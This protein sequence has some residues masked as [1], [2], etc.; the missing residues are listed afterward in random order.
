ML[1]VFERPM[2]VT[3]VDDNCRLFFR[4]AFD[5]FKSFGRCCAQHFF[6]GFGTEKVRKGKVL[7]AKMGPRGRLGDLLGPLGG[8]RA[9]PEASWGP[10]GASFWGDEHMVVFF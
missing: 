1:L 7:G 4:L 5:D 9:P 2:R 10:L 3:T 8:S 6:I